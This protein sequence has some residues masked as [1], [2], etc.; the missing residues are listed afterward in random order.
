MA[1]RE[2]QKK[3]TLKVREG[4]EAGK[5]A[6]IKLRNGTKKKRENK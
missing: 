6:C 1:L 3:K 2:K 5:I 4:E